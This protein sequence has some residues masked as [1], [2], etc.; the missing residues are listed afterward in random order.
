MAKISS[1]IVTIKN[2]EPDFKSEAHKEMY[3]RWL[4]QWND[5]EI[6][7]EVSTKKEPRS[8]QQNRYYWGVYLPL[9][10]DETGHSV[11]ELHALFKGKFLTESIK[12]ILGEKTRI[13][14]SSTE[15]SKGEFCEYLANISTLTQVELP[16]TSHV[17]GYSYHK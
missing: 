6:R 8:A 4:S 16:D 5:K 7:I 2:G 15:L 12:E 17:L 11:E 1:F 14:K 3:T 10:A 13:T 9:I